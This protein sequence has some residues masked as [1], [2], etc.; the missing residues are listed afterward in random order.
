MRR[1]LLLFTLSGALVAAADASPSEGSIRQLLRVNQSRQFI[2]ATRARLDGLI[3]HALQTAQGP[4]IAPK[5]R[6]EIEKRVTEIRSLLRETIAWEKMEPILVRNYQSTFTQEEVNGMIAFYSTP[7]GQSF[8]NK[9]QAKTQN[10]SSSLTF[11]PA[12][13]QGMIAFSQTA[14]GQIL[15]RKIAVVTQSSMK[16]MEQLMEPQM[17]RIERLQQEILADSKPAPR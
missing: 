16:E 8:L 15:F 3:T 7:A 6:Q 17:R 13:I 4:Q 14:S 5:S 1:L 12:E 10:P 2:D 9:I 11:T